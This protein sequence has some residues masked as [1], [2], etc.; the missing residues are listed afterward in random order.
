ML[1]GHL[2]IRARRFTLHYMK[3]TLDSLLCLVSLCVICIYSPRGMRCAQLEHERIYARRLER[4]LAYSIALVEEYREHC[5]RQRRVGMQLVRQRRQLHARVAAL[6]RQLLA[7][8]AQLQS[9]SAA[10]ATSAAS[11]C[12]VLFSSLLPVPVSVS[13]RTSRD[14]M[15]CVRCVMMP[16]PSLLLHSTLHIF[17]NSPNSTNLSI[18]YAGR[19]RNS[20]LPACASLRMSLSSQCSTRSAAQRSASSLLSRVFCLKGRFLGGNMCKNHMPIERRILLR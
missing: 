3:L 18:F 2:A 20:L 1:R 11:V 8:R 16:C 7:L 5:E 19:T 14:L 15:R 4:D 6:S 9:A 13:L 10:T 17:F 12:A